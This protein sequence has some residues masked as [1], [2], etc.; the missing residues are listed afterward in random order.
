LPDLT[1]TGFAAESDCGVVV[2][3]ALCRKTLPEGDVTDSPM[4][5]SYKTFTGIPILG[6]QLPRKF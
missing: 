6:W 1:G 2:L 5:I 4:L 3:V